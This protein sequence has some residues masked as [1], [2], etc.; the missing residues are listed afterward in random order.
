MDYLILSKCSKLSN[1][2]LMS[3]AVKRADP[4]PVSRESLGGG[5]GGGG[6]GGRGSAIS[7]F[8]MQW[9]NSR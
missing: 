3:G 5:G 8:L 4:S 9:R 7:S 1:P 6:G 2:L